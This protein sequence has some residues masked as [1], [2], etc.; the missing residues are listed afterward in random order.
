[1]PDD[2]DQADRADVIVRG[3]PD[4]GDLPLSVIT[5]D[6]ADWIGDD[7]A[8]SRDDLDQAEAA[9]QQHQRKLAAKSSRS[10]F[11]RAMTSG[12]MIPLDQPQ[13]VTSEIRSLIDQC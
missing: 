13:L 8:L 1:M 6:Q 7:F 12:H 10:R 9:W 3:L 2:T 4:L 11:R 5:H